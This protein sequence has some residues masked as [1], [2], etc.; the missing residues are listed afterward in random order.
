MKQFIKFLIPII[1]VFLGVY[2]ILI[3]G[4]WH[5]NLESYVNHRLLENSGWQMSIGEVSGHILSEVKGRQIEFKHAEGSLVLIPEIRANFSLLKSL[6]GVVTIESVEINQLWFNPIFGESE[7]KTE[8]NFYKKNFRGI[9]LEIKDLSLDGLL[10]VS[11]RDSINTIQMNISSSVYPDKD[12]FYIDIQ[13]FKLLH[14]QTNSDFKIVNSKI[15]INS[16]GLQVQPFNALLSMIPIKGRID[17]NWGSEG[18]FVCD[19]RVSNIEI[20]E[21]LFTSTPLQPKFSRLGASLLFQTNFTDYEGSVSVFNALGLDMSGNFSLSKLGDVISIR[22]IKLESDSTELIISGTIEKNGRINGN[23]QLNDFDVSKWITQQRKTDITGLLLFD[24]QLELG[25]IADLSL[26]ME[27]QETELYNEGIISASGSLAYH[28]YILEL[29]DPIMLNIG[30]SSIIADG[31]I[32]FQ[33]DEIDFDIE[34]QDAEVFLI[35]NFWKDSLKSGTATGYME[36]SGNIAEPIIDANLVGRNISYKD[37][38]LDEVQIY[39]SVNNDINIS[40]GFAQFKLGKGTWKNQAFDHGTI[41][42]VFNP[43]E[44]VIENLHVISGE[45]FIQGSAVIRNRQNILIERVQL[46]YDDHYIVNVHPF[47]IEHKN[48]IWNLNPFVLHVDDG[49]VEGHLRL[50]GLTEGQIDLRNIDAQILSYLIKSPL[51]KMDGTLFGNI[52]FDVSK[53]SQDYHVNAS[54]KNG[55]LIDEKF[56]NLDVSFTL[57][58][59]I[60]ELK[61]LLIMEKPGSFADI[62]GRI[63]LGKEHENPDVNINST[64]KNLNIEILTQFIPNWYYLGGRVNGDF[65]LSGTGLNTRF[66]FSLDI[67]NAEFEKIQI[68]SAH[69]SGNFDGRILAFSEFSLGRRIDQLAGHAFLPIDLNFTSSTFGKVFRNDS[70]DVKVA[71]STDNMDFLSVYL[72]E[73][74]SIRGEIDLKLILSGR[75]TDIVRDGYLNVKNGSIYTTLLEKPIVDLKGITKLEKNQFTIES[76]EGKMHPTSKRGKQ[77]DNRNISFSGDLNMTRFFQPFYNIQVLGND[78]YFRSLINDF[79]GLVDVDI[80]IVGRDTIGIEGEIA[81]LDVIMFRPLIANE[82]GTVPNESSKILINYNM[83]FPIKGDFLLTNNQLDILL[84][85]EISI[86][87]YGDRPSDFSGELNIRE[88]K[89]YYYGDIFT[90]ADGYMGFE[91]KGF[92]PYLD[93]NAF[94]IIDDE[95]I[96]VSIVGPIDNPELSF[97]SSSGFSHSDILE[98][99]TWRKRFEDQK[100]S[101]SGLGT[102]AQ[103]VVGAWFDSQLDKNIME[104]S[105]LNNL[106]IVDD[107]S[108]T[109]ASG[110]LDPYNIDD[111]SIKAD[112]SRTLSL[113]YAYRRSFSLSNPLHTLGVELKVNRYLSLVGNVDRTGNMQVKYRLRYAY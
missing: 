42:L 27:I 51:L 39:A 3:P 113:N 65:N 81:V 2:I 44:V 26:T 62:I 31:T 22:N 15:A 93:I 107:V 33:S 104:L 105:G 28:D 7:N 78:V 30:P 70:I 90:I 96:D 11:I 97:T 100:I 46:A 89:F 77:K 79:Q 40:D 82:L 67:E 13:Y 101:S 57:R 17:Y 83:N 85:G 29:V 23:L 19:L 53:G 47:E 69:G 66:N 73:V 24:A 74:D 92:N 112:L 71:G 56:D 95:E 48:D 64:F 106:G 108:I 8:T 9:P 35:N 84:D 60:L 110:L 36:I 94:T 37:F 52:I 34:L 20:P 87:K 10:V 72:T 21:K 103:Q 18:D 49:V 75:W 16:N 54:I 58:N 1:I 76:L 91:K 6:K 41:D 63:P 43:K 68:G 4:I 50:N 14:T 98:L 111:F 109:G 80:A 61:K 12:N 38:L 55:H 25:E 32:D 59:K 88:G 45:E 99:L 5:K 86:T 102:Q